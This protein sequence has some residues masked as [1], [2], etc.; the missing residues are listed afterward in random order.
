VDG[1]GD[2]VPERT[3]RAKPT[4]GL[5][6]GEGDEAQIGAS[7][8]EWDLAVLSLMEAA[9]REPGMGAEALVGTLGLGGDGTRRGCSKRW[10]GGC[11]AP[12]SSG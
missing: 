6:I 5:G 10:C 8:L 1:A 3:W 12:G 11:G 2:G 9:A 7:Y 4:D